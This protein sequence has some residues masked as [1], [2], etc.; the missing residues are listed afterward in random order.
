MIQEGATSFWEGYDTSWYKEDFHSSLQAD[1]RSGYFVSLAHGWSTGP[2]AW[3]M[4]EVLGIQSTG[5]GFSTVD[6]RPDLLDLTWAKGAEPTP[7]GLLQVDI[8]KSGAATAISVD[9]PPG[10]TARVAVPVSSSTAQVMLDGKPLAATPAENGTR[11]IV[12]LEHPGHFNLS[13]Q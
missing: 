6:I 7:H 12:T 10:V 5:G 3:L 8:L 1:N 13:G 2:T 4:E 11:M 9:V